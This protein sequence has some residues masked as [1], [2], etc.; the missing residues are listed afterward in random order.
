MAMNTNELSALITAKMTEKLG[1]SDHAVIEAY[2]SLASAVAEA[3]IEHITK[4]LTVKSE[5]KL[6][7]A[8]GVVATGPGTYPVTGLIVT[9]STVIV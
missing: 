7:P 1:A 8:S 9:N 4:R 6:T 5:V 3:V 2:S